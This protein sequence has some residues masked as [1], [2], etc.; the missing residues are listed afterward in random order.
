MRLQLRGFRVVLTLWVY[1][2]SYLNNTF[3]VAPQ[4]REFE[5]GRTSRMIGWAR[6]LQQKYVH[7]KDKNWVAQNNMKCQLRPWSPVGTMGYGQQGGDATTA[8]QDADVRRLHGYCHLTLTSSKYISLSLLSLLSS[9]ALSSTLMFIE[10]MSSHWVLTCHLLS[11]SLCACHAFSF[12][13]TLN[14]PTPCPF[15]PPEPIDNSHN[16]NCTPHN[17]Y[18]PLGHILPLHIVISIFVLNDAVCH[19]TTFNFI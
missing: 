14:R 10:S 13:V 7:V 17:S 16:S 12:Q 15:N 8:G 1:L 19:L 4:W 3:H 9:S 11:S 2:N 5:W 18:P 6:R